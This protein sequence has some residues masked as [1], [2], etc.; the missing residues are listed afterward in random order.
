[1][2]KLKRFSNERKELVITIK[3]NYQIRMKAIDIAK[4]FQI[5]KQNVNYWLHHPV[6]IKRKRRTKLIRR[7]EINIIIK[8]ARDESINICYANKIRNKLDLL[9]KRRKEKG[10]KKKI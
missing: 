9:S 6:I 2:V 8:C 4:L 3:K 5:L 10:K 1:M 7:A